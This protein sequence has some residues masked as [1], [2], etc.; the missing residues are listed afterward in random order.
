VIVPGLGLVPTDAVLTY[1]QLRAIANVPVEAGNT[2]Y[3]APLLR[4]A[5]LLDQHAGPTCRYVLL[6]SIAT[7]KYTRPLLNVFGERLLFPAEFVGRGDMSRGGLML[8][9]ARTSEE[10]SYVA[11]QGAVRHGRRPPKLEPWRKQ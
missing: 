10:L 1:D 3:S 7:E 9:C 5:L 2:A 6:G 8:R 4:D 11:V